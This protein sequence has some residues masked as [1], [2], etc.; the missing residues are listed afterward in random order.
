VIIGQEFFEGTNVVSHPNTFEFDKATKVFF[1]NINTRTVPLTS[2]QNL[3]VIIDDDEKFSDN[4]LE[5]I[6]YNKSGSY[7][8][9]TIKT[10]GNFNQLRYIKHFIDNEPRNILKSLFDYLLLDDIIEDNLIDKVIDSLMTLNE[11]YKAEP[12]LKN[13]KNKG[14]FIALLFYYIKDKKKFL[15]FVEWVRNNHLS[16]IEYVRSKSL[17]HIYDK[18]Y[19]KKI[20]KLF[21]AM[22]YYSHSEITEYNKLYKEICSEISKKANIELELIPIMRFRGKSQRIDQRLLDKI[23]ECDIFIADISENNINV[24]FE[25]GYA[26]SREIPMILLKNEKDKTIVPFDMDKLQYLPYQDRGY[27]NDIKMKVTGN[28]KEILEKDFNINI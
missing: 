18:I 22:P 2:E 16:E 13:N 9:Q 21:V 6:F 17:I 19:E 28:I 26:D 12:F 20:F 10:V 25:V 5:E 3:K 4:E 15:G 11:L 27:Y 14:L 23:K 8:R 7:V 24:I 1:H